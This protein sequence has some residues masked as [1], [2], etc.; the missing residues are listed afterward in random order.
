M[1]QPA[2]MESNG[3]HTLDNVPSPQQ[4]ASGKRKRDASDDG[5]GIDDGVERKPATA[6]ASP[7]PTRDL[8]ELTKHC[9]EALSRYVEALSAGANDACSRL[10][11]LP[12]DARD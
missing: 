4:I 9:F 2:T 5:E 8:H 12:L 6:T 11:S 10:A 1:A 7:P 3:A